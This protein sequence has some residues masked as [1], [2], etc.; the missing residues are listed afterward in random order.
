[1][2]VICSLM[3]AVEFSACGMK[4]SSSSKMLLGAPPFALNWQG[5][6]SFFLGL[7]AAKGKQECIFEIVVIVLK[8]L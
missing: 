6:S 8:H 5:Q 4:R 3:R 7:D 2:V 1:M